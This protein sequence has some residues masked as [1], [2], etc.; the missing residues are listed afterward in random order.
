MRCDV[1][2]TTEESSPLLLT[3]AG[4]KNPSISDAMVALLGKPI[5]ECNA[6]A[7][8]TAGYA[9]GGPAGAWRFITGKATTP[10]SRSWGWKSLG[11]FV[12][13]DA[14]ERLIDS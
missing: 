5:A 11:C 6:L 10:M 4:I 9:M 3:S 13:V 1:V 12:I 8:P 2:R 7:I 14:A